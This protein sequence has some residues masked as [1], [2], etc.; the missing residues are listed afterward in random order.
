M[1][2]IDALR[3]GGWPESELGNALGIVSHEDPSGDPAMPSGYNA[4]GGEDSWGL[5]QVNRMAHPQYSV[6]QLCDPVFNA[7]VAYQLFVARGNCY[8][9]WWYSSQALGVCPFGSAQ[10]S[11]SEFAVLA[12]VDVGGGGAPGTQPPGE[13]VMPIVLGAVGVFLLLDLLTD[14]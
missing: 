4:G 8:H 5:F 13:S 10:H 14:M 1:L 9:D 3:A 12:N 7:T 6:E 2:L 11:I